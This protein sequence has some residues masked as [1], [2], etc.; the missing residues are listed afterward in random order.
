MI[1]CVHHG[2]KSHVSNIVEIEKLLADLDAKH[3]AKE[4]AKNHTIQLKEN[5]LRLNKIREFKAGLYESMVNEVLSKEEY[6]ALKAKYT[7][8]AELLTAANV[9]LQQEIEDIL[10]CSNERMAWIEHF[11]RF[12]NIETID[13]KTVICLIHS[14]HVHS[15][16][17]IEITYDHQADYDNALS[18]IAK[19][20]V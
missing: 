4:L 10:S 16:S 7:E 9:K 18:L 13:R 20:A 1:Y 12:E 19:E 6:K 2:I 3:I 8:D 5:D 14:I 15:K 11:K 17:E